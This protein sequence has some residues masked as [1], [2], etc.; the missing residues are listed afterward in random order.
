MAETT[1]LVL[2]SF[3]GSFCYVYYVWVVPKRRR[4]SVLLKLRG[5][6]AWLPEIEEP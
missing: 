6:R 2:S 4:V 5:S 3:G 1:V